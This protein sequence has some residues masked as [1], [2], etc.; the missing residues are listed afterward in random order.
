[1]R[2][3]GSFEQ[4]ELKDGDVK[5]EGERILEALQKRRG[6]RVYALAEEGVALRSV[7]LAGKLQALQGQQAIFVVGG[8]FGLS[9]AVKGRADVLLSLSPLT[10]THEI[11]RM[12]LC[13]QLYRAVS[14]QAGSNYHHE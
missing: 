9:D 4:I 1:L 12:L 13:E 14:I 7:D 2:R 6:A 3:S 8:A 5:S 11:A 10:F